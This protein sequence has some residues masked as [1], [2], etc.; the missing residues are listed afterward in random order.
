MTVGGSHAGAEIMLLTILSGA[1]FV[2]V[3][4]N[5]LPRVGVSSVTGNPLKAVGVGLQMIGLV[6]RFRSRRAAAAPAARRRFVAA[7]APQS[8][9]A[10]RM[11]APTLTRSRPSMTSR[12]P[13]TSSSTTCASAPR[14]CVAHCPPG[15][16]ST[17]AA[18]P[19]SLA[20]APRR[21]GYQMVGVDPSEG[22][23]E[24]MRPAPEVEAVQG[25]GTELPFADDR[26]DLVLTVAAMHHIAEPAD[27]RQTLAEMVRV[28][29]PAD[30][31]WS[32][33]TTPA[34]LTG[35]S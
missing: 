11:S 4:V 18:A 14:S 32:G 8:D 31:S 13:P 22:M 24:I 23:L 1:R 27:V 26:F 29:S 20:A 9:R 28:P 5:Y 12:S 16:V 30:G 3:P 34:T 2:E 21:S 10:I 35:E 25:S 33:T 15:A 17:S 7:R 6:L 19:A